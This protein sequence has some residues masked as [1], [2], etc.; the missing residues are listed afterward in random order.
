M[1]NILFSD[2]TLEFAKA[3]MEY[4]LLMEHVR[5]QEEA[6]FID[7]TSKILPLLYIKTL[8]MEEPEEYYDS[9]LEIGVTEEKYAWVT[10][11]IADLLGEKDLFLETFHPDM[12]YSDTPVAVTVSENLADI[13]QDL[14]NFIAVFQ[15]GIMETMNDALVACLRNFKDYW[16]QNLVNVLRAVHH[17]RN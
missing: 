6:D 8:L 17:L 1:T 16:G 14:G 10:A 12:P 2:R 15:L 4:C 3:A 5:E 7:K 13:Y 11:G 9:D